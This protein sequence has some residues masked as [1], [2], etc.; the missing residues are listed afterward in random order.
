[1]SAIRKMF[2]E[3]T[4]FG[5]QYN[6]H[7]FFSSHN[8]V[9]EWNPSSYISWYTHGSLERHLKL[10]TLWFTLWSVQ[11]T[12]SLTCEFSNGLSVNFSLYLS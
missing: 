5:M 10:L 4:L 1:M 8:A 2:K 3:N 11:K 9:Y 7:V 12:T 6:N